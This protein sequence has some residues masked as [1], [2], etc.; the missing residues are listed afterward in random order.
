VS[1]V[2]HVG[3]YP[4]VDVGDDSGIVRYLGVEGKAEGRCDWRRAFESR[5]GRVAG[6]DR[7]GEGRANLLQ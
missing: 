6:A 3:G 1:E 7:M 4:L 5:L 2:C